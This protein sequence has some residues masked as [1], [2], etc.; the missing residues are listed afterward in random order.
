MMEQIDTYMHNGVCSYESQSI[1]LQSN[2]ERQGL[3]RPFPTVVERREYN[4]G[5]IVLPGKV[6][7]GYQDPEKAQDMDD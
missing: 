7:H 6:N 2:K 3:R 4:F 1:T 5:R